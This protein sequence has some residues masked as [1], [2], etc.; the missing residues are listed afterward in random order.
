VRGAVGAVIGGA[1]VGVAGRLASRRSRPKVLGIP[2]PNELNPKR[3]DVSRFT[4]GL[5]VNQLAS[6]VDVKNVA[7]NVD[8]KDV[9]RHIGNIAE[10]LEAGSEDVRALSGQAK[11]LSRRIG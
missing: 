3:L 7:K 2:I 4:K 5:D 10:R 11:R 8:I 9:M 6:H 1:A